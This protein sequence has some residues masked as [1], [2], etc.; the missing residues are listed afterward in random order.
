MARRRTDQPAMGV[1]HEDYAR[2]YRR[3]HPLAIW[4]CLSIA[5]IGI[6]TLLA[7]SQAGTS[8][9]SMALPPALLKAFN[10]GY[11]IGG[12]LAA[13]GLIR[14]VRRAEAAGMAIL[15][16]VLLTQYVSII[17]VLP[18]AWLTGTFVLSLAIGCG[19]RAW[20]LTVR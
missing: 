9:T 18:S 6:V 4:F 14:A 1:R 3:E 10:L 2:A 7:P 16:S 8:A 15:S 5:F 11:F 13:Y 17:Y 19:R 12:A 20:I